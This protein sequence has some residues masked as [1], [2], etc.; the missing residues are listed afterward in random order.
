M[1][2]EIEDAIHYGPDSEPIGNK[3]YNCQKRR[4]TEH[5]S[6]KPVYQFRLWS[7]VI[8]GASFQLWGVV[9]VRRN[10]KFLYAM[11]VINRL[12]LLTPT[13]QKRRFY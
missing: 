2:F 1:A 7:A 4:D 10:P 11:R 13:W 12:M 8:E 9:R 6:V 5:L 3:L